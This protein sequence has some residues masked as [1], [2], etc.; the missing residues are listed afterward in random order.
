MAEDTTT[1]NNESLDEVET[2]LD[3]DPNG[4]VSAESNNPIPVGPPPKPPL[5]KRLINGLFG[6]NIYLLLF[7][8]ILIMAGAIVLFTMSYSKKQTGTTNINTTSLSQ[9]TLD[10]LASGDVSVGSSNQVLSVQSSA[11]FA[12]KVLVRSDLEVA[13]NLQV[14]G[15]LSLASL[16]VNDSA[17][18][19]K[20]DISQNLSVTGDV[21]VQGQQT[22]AKS[23][24]VA[25]N[26]TFN[27]TLSAP[28]ISTTNLQLNGDLV[29]TRHLI[30]GGGTP[31]RSNGT[32]VGS[33]GSASVSGSDTSGSVSI[34]TG[35]GTSAGCFITVGFTSKYAA[36]PHVLVTPVGADAGVVDYYITKSTTGFSICTSTAAPVSTSFGFDYFVTG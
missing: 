8:F 24:Q 5:R 17:Q 21:A 29:L 36:L 1:D 13:G 18:L 20:T 11:V 30:T 34:N 27:G 7:V 2:A 28:T 16:S 25:G 4:V 35:G 6:F 23:L 31:S 15:K 22:V 9:D 14:G 19:G 12:G 3:N 33:G 32:A 26:G 10:K